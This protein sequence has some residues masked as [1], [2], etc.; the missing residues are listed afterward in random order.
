MSHKAGMGQSTLSNI[1]EAN[2]RRSLGVTG[3]RTHKEATT[4]ATAVLPPSS[5]AAATTSD[6]ANSIRSAST[7]AN[8]VRNWVVRLGGWPVRE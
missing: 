1:Q 4:G 7:R 5:P 3:M 2:S 6:P 8:M